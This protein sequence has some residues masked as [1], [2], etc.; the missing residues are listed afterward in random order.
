MRKTM[1][2]T[3]TT[4]ATDYP[5]GAW[6]MITAD[7]FTAGSAVMFKV[8]HVSGPGPDGSYGTV[9]DR[10][11]HLGGEGHTW[12]KVTDGGAGDLD[13]LAN[14]KLVTSWYVNPDDSLNE[15]F[16]LT[17]RGMYGEVAR[18]TFT[19]SLPTGA[20]VNLTQAGSTG[21]VDGA[22]FSNVKYSAGTGVIDPFVRIQA[23]GNEQGY[24]SGA[25]GA[26][27]NPQFNETGKYG[28]TYNHALALKDVPIAYI[29]NQGSGQFDAYYQ[30][31]LD[32]NENSNA[33]GQQFLSLDAF[34]IYQSNSG[35]LSN[36]NAST[37]TFNNQAQY[38]AYDLDA[39]GNKWV[40]LNY[41]LNAGSGVGDMSVYVPVSKFNNANYVYVYSQFGQQASSPG[42]LWESSAGFEEWSIGKGA[43]RAVSTVTGS[44]FNDANGNGIREAGET[45]IA[46]V[47]IYF[48]QNQNGN[49]EW[50]DQNNNSTWDPGEGE[51]W[52]VTDASGNYTFTNVPAGLGTYSTYYVREV[53]PAGYTQ[54]GPLNGTYTVGV[55]AETATVTGNSIIAVQVKTADAAYILPAFGNQLNFTPTPDFT[56]TKTATLSDGAADQAGDVITYTV[57]VKNTGNVALTN[58]AVTDTFEGAAPQQ[59][60]TIASLGA[61]TEQ[62]FTY[63]YT[64]QQSD[65]DGNGGSDGKLT[66]VAT[67]TA[68]DLVRS[69]TEDVAL[70]L[71]PDLSITKTA[72]L[73]DGAADQAGDVI[74]YKVIVKNTGNVALTNVAV[75]DTFEGADPQQLGTIASLG[76]GT[77][78]AIT[79]TYTLQQSDL[80]GNGGNDGKLTNVA[81]A[82]AGDLVR[83]ST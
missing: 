38:L 40:A 82:T 56:I 13:G 49:L 20:T 17:A 45:A 79:Y 65:L 67:A 19:D 43:P 26:S 78:Q 11:K 39:G 75:T 47:K 32:I 53:V 81:K 37:G 51:R 83:P 36:Y 23:N 80:D 4:D 14:G 68:G 62:A 28:T 50:I 9:D 61:G 10:V 30:F 6:A 35:T 52:T 5:P 8:E 2:T 57:I 7:G 63:T 12:W 27:P 74:T 55:G 1:S 15:T 72:M 33:Q 46:N 42:F 77:E 16:R 48:D 76:A 3:V 41:D 29:F 64:L 69:D 44:K 24:N 54:T 60:G 73:S 22:L 66:N 34:K 18:T 25:T 31:L 59:V 71:R 58:V 70:V 21:V